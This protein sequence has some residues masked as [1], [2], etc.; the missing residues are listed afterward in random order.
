MQI[1]P[2]T[3]TGVRLQS[4]SLSGQVIGLCEKVAGAMLYQWRYATVQAPT[5]YTMTDINSK[6]RVI[7][8]NLVPGTQY[9]VQVRACGRRGSSD[10]SDPMPVYAV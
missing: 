3:P 4:G 10:W 8:G 2:D 9:L 6:V 1:A 5:A 7:L